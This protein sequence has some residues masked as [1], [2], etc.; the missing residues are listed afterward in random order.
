MIHRIGRFIFVAVF[1]VTVAWFSYQWVTDPSGRAERA[2]QE[3]V[4]LRARAE[5][6]RAIQL[7]DLEFVDPLAPRRAVGKVYVFQKQ[8]RWEVSGYY[9]RGTADA[10]HPFLITLDNELLWQKLKVKD[11]LVTDVVASD[12][13]IEV[14]S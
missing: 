6:S 5:L 4:V 7:R 9:R 3:R 14:S 12:P 11:S 1:S 2:L 13:N 8:D 10:W